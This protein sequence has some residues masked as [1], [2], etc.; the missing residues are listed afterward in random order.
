[1]LRRLLFPL[2]VVG[3]LL[4]GAESPGF[5]A[6]LAQAPV[7]AAARERVVAE[8]QATGAAGILPD[9]RLGV[10]VGQDRPRAGE[11]GNRLEVSLEQPLPRWG[12][13]DGARLAAQAAILRSEAE[14]ALLAGEQAADITAMLAETAAWQ[15]SIA[16]RQ[17]ARTRLDGVIATIQTRIASGGAD[18]GALLALTT[19]AEA[20][21]LA[22]DDAER[23]A[24]DAAAEA[25][26]R[27]GLPPT[28]TLPEATFP[29][30]AA[31]ELP[32]SPLALRAAAAGAEAEADHQ[33]ALA[34]GRP[35]TS[36]GV[37]WEREQLGRDG[38]SDLVKLLVSVSLPV[39]P[40]AF[41]ARA[42]AAQAR[43]RAA[44]HELA[45][46]RWLAA[47][48]RARA[49]RA[50]GQAARAMQV[51]A[52]LETRQGAEFAR[53]CQQIASG[54][55][56]FAQALD[57]LDQLTEAKQQALDAALIRDQARADLWRI[58]P[59]NLPVQAKDHE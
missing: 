33:T 53:L 21:T 43:A 11:R 42:E 14:F 27:L 20:L 28:A 48:L 57:A 54:G 13:R 30:L 24:T 25:R 5:I 9:P 37:S 3:G 41:A 46:S 38:E 18:S 47:S 16:L 23:R 19:R 49:E 58:A 31:G 6:T 50:T 55:D 12:E 4:T 26:A 22:H 15:A 29:T 7:L 44:R 34:R 45:N 39:Q 51:A 32:A 17:A 10:A 8:R 2:F 52:N 35:E 59:P 56:G 1:M 36:V 40:T